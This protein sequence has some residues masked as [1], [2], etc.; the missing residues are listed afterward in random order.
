ML[1]E[2]RVFWYQTSGPVTVMSLMCTLPARM[3]FIARSTE[4][5]PR[6]KMAFVP[7]FSSSGLPMTRLRMRISPFSG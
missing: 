7:N 5:P 4:R 1:L 6:R 2:V 3:S